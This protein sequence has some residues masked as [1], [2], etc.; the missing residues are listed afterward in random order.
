[1]TDNQWV[2]VH[3][4][5]KSVKLAGT[6]LFAYLVNLTTV[7]PAAVAHTVTLHAVGL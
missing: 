3:G 4:L 6:S 5:N 1:L 7:T 2:E